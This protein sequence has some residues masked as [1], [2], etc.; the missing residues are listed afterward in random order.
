MNYRMRWVRFLAV[1]RWLV[2]NLLVTGNCSQQ[3]A[4]KQ[5]VCR[6]NPF[7]L[8]Y[9]ILV[10]SPGKKKSPWCNVYGFLL[11]LLVDDDDDALLF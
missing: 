3:I 7:P 9:L 8:F 2:G 6:C 5:N 11:L 4:G 10:R 1:R